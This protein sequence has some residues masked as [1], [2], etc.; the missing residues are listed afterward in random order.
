MSTLFSLIQKEHPD[1]YISKD[2]IK[3]FTEIENFCRYISEKK[4][5]EIFNFYIIQSFFTPLPYKDV[6]VACMFKDKKTVKGREDIIID[7]FNTHKMDGSGKKYFEIDL[8]FWDVD[9]TTLD[10]ILEKQN[11]RGANLF[12]KFSSYRCLPVTQRL[13]TNCWVRLAEPY[14][15]MKHVERFDAGIKYPKPLLLNPYVKLFKENL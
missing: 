11:V 2:K 8:H 3:Y 9:Y 14:E 6:D 1:L 12:Y 4:Q 5:D 13:S 10:K 7:L 15:T